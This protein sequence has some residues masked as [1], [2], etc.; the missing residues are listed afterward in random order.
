MKRLLGQAF[1]VVAVGITAMAFTPACADNDQTIYVRNVVAPPSNRQNGRCIYQPDPAG[2]GL[3]EGT[4]DVAIRGDYSAILLVG[5][6]GLQRAD[7]LNARVEP[8]RAH[9]NGAVVTVTDPNGGTINE[10]TALG[11]GFVDPGQGTTPSFGLI[12][13]TLIDQATSTR[14]GVAPGAP[15]KLVVANAK[16]FGKTLGGVD[17]ESGEFQFPI[18]VCN[19][20]LLDFSTGDDLAVQGRD[21]NRTIDTT[22]GGGGSEPPCTPGQDENTPCQF[23]REFRRECRGEQP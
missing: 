1:V 19:G 18:R 20:C 2:V 13:V 23:C 3:L 21:C 10:F 12:G 14:I 8:N 9:L 4:L 16:V 11:S 6:Q 17:L 15:A 7:A 5:G 22:A